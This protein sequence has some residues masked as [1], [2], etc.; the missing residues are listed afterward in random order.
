MR[1]VAWFTLLG[2]MTFSLAGQTVHFHDGVDLPLEQLI[3]RGNALIE[4]TDVQ[5][6]NGVVERVRRLTDIVRI[7]WPEPP[8]LAEARL[9]LEKGEGARA[10]SL[11]APL[12]KEHAPFARVPGGWWTE[13]MRVYLRGLLGSGP[14]ATRQAAQAAREIAGIASDPDA[15]HE[16]HLALAELEIRSGRPD[17]AEA[18]LRGIEERATSARLLAAIQLVRADL[19]L[20]RSETTEAI[21]AYLQVW[22]FFGTER[23]LLPRALKGAI[24]AF[25]SSG[26]E[27]QALRLKGELARI[28]PDPGEPSDSERP[29]I[30]VA[31]TPSPES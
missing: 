10:V 6:D 12:K 4:R 16:A 19:S 23:D 28:Q 5:G 24:T 31:P 30:S 9:A 21:E 22:V 13:I 29:A 3:L 18:M 8:S 25:E 26:N 17:L 14:E 20:A 1:L 7:A 11:L 2:A 15:I 27:T